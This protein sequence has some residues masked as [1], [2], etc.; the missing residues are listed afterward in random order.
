MKIKAK[1]KKFFRV[2]T[3]LFDLLGNQGQVC[4][5]STGVSVLKERDDQLSIDFDDDN[6]CIIVRMDSSGVYLG[7]ARD[8]VRCDCKLFD[9]RG[10][11]VFKDN[12]RWD[13]AVE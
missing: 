8:G 9:S 13:S 3:R 2:D 7:V 10:N 11:W 6:T 12:C 4:M 5:N 1:S